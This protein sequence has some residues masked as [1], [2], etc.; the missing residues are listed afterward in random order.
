MLKGLKRYR[1]PPSDNPAISAAYIASAI[2]KLCDSSHEEGDEQK[3]CG[4]G[5]QKPAFPEK[6]H[7]L[8]PPL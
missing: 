4:A 5:E 8:L 6:V 2:S 3:G 1:E 7:F